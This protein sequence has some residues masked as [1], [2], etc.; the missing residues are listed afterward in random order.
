MIKNLLRYALPAFAWTTIIT[1][2]CLMPGKDLPS[3]SIVN[4]DKFV[5]VSFFGMLNFLYLRWGVFGN[6]L[7]LSSIKITIFT[8]FYGGSI[9]IIQG[10][11]YTDRHADL[12]DFIANT[13]GALIA[14][15]CIRFTPKFLK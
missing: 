4:F 13:A 3:V 12:M 9:E 15:Y 14:L 5:H 8:I 6:G 7:T 11:F 1:V 10:T 2:L